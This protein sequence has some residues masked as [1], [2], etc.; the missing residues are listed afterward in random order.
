M[1]L[2]KILFPKIPFL[3]FWL[4]FSLNIFSNNDL[5]VKAEYDGLI[6]EIFQ[7]LNEDHF[8]KNTQVTEE[9]VLTNFL[10]NLDKEKVIFTKKESNSFLS[11]FK[12]IFNLKQVFDIYLSYSN[13][14]LELI[15]SQK[16]IVESLKNTSDLNSIYF[17]DKNRENKDS[18]NSLEEIKNYHSLL[19]KNEFISVLLS[20]DDFVSTKRK[21]L[22]RLDN[23]IKSLN[24]IKS[25]DIFSLYT[26]S[27]T[28]L[29]DPHTNYLS[30]KSQEDF[31]INMSLSL[32]GIGAILSIEDGITKIVRLI[33]G[34]P[35][36]KSGLLKV[37]D[38][39]VGVASLPEKDLEDVRDW[40][41][42]EVVRLIRGPKNTRVRLE[43]I[44]NSSPDDILGKVIEITRGL[45]KLEDQAA[46]K[47]QIE[48]FKT[49]K[50]Y[51]IGVIDLPAFYM[52]FDAF[53][54]NQF[55]YKSSSKDVRNLLR[56]LKEEQV[57]GVI[58]D[59]R[60]NSGGSLYEAYSLAKLF[61]GKGSVVQV[62]ES[63]GSIQ[64]LGHT[65]GLQ[66]YAGPV[67]ILVD[68]LSASAS[69]ILAGAFQDYKRGLVVGTSTFGKGTVQRLENLSY[70]Q[71]KF[72]EQKF[73]RVSGKSTQNL[74]V[75]PDI[76]LPFVF[77]SEEI[78]EMTLENS[79]PYDDISS[80]EY[81]PFDSTSNIDM[82][83]SFS[84][85]R[86]LDSNL[87]EYIKGQ[88]NYA[89]KEIEKELIPVNYLVRK[90]KKRS[91]EEKRLFIENKFRTSLGLKPYLNF[92]EFLDADPEEINEFSE[93]MVLEEAARI[94][95][96]QINF[97]KPKRLSRV[98]SR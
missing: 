69:E 10:L 93:K 70:G 89:K 13:R 45:V 42:D 52:D 48:I 22:K 5:E 84:R 56:E 65:R 97:S 7:I 26:N 38:K 63:N 54:K 2:K 90:S 23:R 34:G 49:N 29:Y 66:N 9:K 67:L 94:L 83:Q 12:N 81:A 25:D 31:E 61:I 41:I 3:I 44:P 20:N 91:Q 62:M 6:S 32:E 77:D 76:N 64:P 78:G 27:I 39:I 18:F 92:Q 95:I 36:D 75:V 16:L 28:S 96:D 87:N 8:K 46:K 68:K 60:G 40:R 35:A 57:D 43:I 24:R 72:T 30:P 71:L 55:N 85:K 15:N 33:P 82:I 17:I 59:L 80:L 88:K 14:S 37:N 50:S 58:L 51:N 1:F 73:Y 98:E 11:K 19:I 79:L 21:I 4:F 53:S 86:V 74:G 47:K